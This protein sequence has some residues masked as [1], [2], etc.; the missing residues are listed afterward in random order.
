MLEVIPIEAQAHQAPLAQIRDGQSRVV[1]F[2]EELTYVGNLLPTV[3]PALVTELSLASFISIE[4]T[5]HSFERC[6]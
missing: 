1:G 3:H 6:V 2:P 4:D 5:E